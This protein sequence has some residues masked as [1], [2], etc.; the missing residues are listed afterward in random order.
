MEV[1]TL[2]SL[3]ARL[4]INHLHSPGF[5]VPGLFSIT[6]IYHSVHLSTQHSSMSSRSPSHVRA[7]H[8]RGVERL[9]LTGIYT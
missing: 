2:P 9:A 8:S 5:I 3:L 6:R 4:P 1:L 7:S